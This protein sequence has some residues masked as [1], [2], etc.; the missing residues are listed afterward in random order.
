MRALM[1]CLLA[2]ALAAPAAANPPRQT[3]KTARLFDDAAPLPLIQLIVDEADWLWLE[4]HATD[5]DY[6][7]AEVIYDGD[8]YA[9]AAVRYKGSFGSL[10]SCFDE[11]GQR[12]C[13]KLSLKVSFNEYDRG[14]RFEGV[15]KL[16]L[17]SCGRD[18][19]CIHERLSYRMFAAAGVPASRAVHALVSVNGGPASYYTLVE[20][21]DKEWIQDRYDDDDGNLYKEVWPQHL[22]DAPYRAALRAGEGDVS[23]MV[24]F[25]TL[26]A[27]L[28]PGDDFAALVG[29]WLDLAVMARYLAVDQII[30]NWDGVWKFYCAGQRCGNHNFFIYDDPATGRL[31][32]APWD[33]D[34]TFERPNRDL[35]RS[36]WDDGPDACKVDMSTAIVGVRAPQCDAL[37]RGLMRAGWDDYRAALAVLTDPA[38][39]PL[40]EAR[41]LALVDRYRAMLVDQVGVDPLGPGPDAWRRASAQLRQIIRAQYREVERFLAE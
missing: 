7:P 39:G 40:S 13:P 37:L 11:A 20:N 2:L 14:G 24:A 19:G 5:E 38:A 34:R 26:L 8:R 9:G 12:L 10:Y 41:V 4:A 22:R 35:A 17:N 36:W 30:N 21:V 33:L 3:G 25:A 28:G 23:R 32:V 18:P 6:V 15:R 31:V 1:P 29:P 16:V 27:G